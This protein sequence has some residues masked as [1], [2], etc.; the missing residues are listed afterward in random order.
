[1]GRGQLYEVQQG[2]VPGPALGSQQPHAT[3]QAWGRVAGKM[4]GRKE[5]GDVAQQQAEHE[6]AVCP[7]GQESQQH[8]GL[9][10]EW[11]GQQEQGGDLAPVL[12]TAE[13]VPLVLCSVL[14][15]SLQGH[16]VA[17]AY[18]KK[19]NKAGEGSREQDLWGVAG[20]TG[21]V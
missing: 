21:I 19:G 8:P 10:Q 18:P 20:G 7:G 13:A 17:E 9:Y 4:P 16:W 12:G 2:Q 15:P 3:L 6:P 1:M 5:P 11:C 14:G